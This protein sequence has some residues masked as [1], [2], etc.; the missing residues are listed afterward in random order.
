MAT[1]VEIDFDVLTTT[2]YAIRVEATDGKDTATT[3]VTVSIVNVNEAPSFTG[4]NYIISDT[5]N[6]VCKEDIKTFF[7]R[8]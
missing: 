7:F 4:A 2:S 6:V 8:F 1:K 5:E 3:S